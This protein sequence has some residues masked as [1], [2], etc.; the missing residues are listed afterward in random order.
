VLLL[1]LG[2]HVPQ[3]EF[4]YVLLGD[5][6]VLAPEAHYYQRLLALDED[7]AHDVAEQF[8]K[9]KPTQELYDSVLIPAL[10]LAE[11]D[12][13]ESQLD[14]ERLRFIYQTTRDL[15]EEMGDHIGPEANDH[16]P[17]ANYQGKILCIPARD[18]ADE[19]VAQM[20]CQSLRE[21]GYDAKSLRVDFV[22]QMLREVKECQPDVLFVS[23]LPP[24]A[25]THAR[26]L[27]RRARNVCN[28]VKVAIGLWGATVDRKMLQQRL[29][30]GCSDYL[31]YSIAEAELQL[32]LFAGGTNENNHEE[33][34][35]TRLESPEDAT[36][37]VFTESQN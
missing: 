6:P 1:V 35:Q 7:E 31:V 23:A 25:V 20:L 30:A 36:Q 21:Q 4:L 34:E 22:E 28:G 9:G 18:E 37:P 32:R 26:S 12:R 17:S 14:E 33:L 5:E 2:R 16:R 29:G 3:F 13:H 11:E 24:F 19:L 27:C 10:A 15:I 8:V